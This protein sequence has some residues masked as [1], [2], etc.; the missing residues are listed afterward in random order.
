VARLDRVYEGKEPLMVSLFSAT[1][2]LL[3]LKKKQEHAFF[4]EDVQEMP[5]LYREQTGK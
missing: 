4:E 3:I 1:S 5:S 2:S